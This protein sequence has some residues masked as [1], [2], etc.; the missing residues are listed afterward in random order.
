M[1]LALV[2]QATILLG[3]WLLVENT[4]PSLQDIGARRQEVAQLEQQVIA[5]ER[6]GGRLE[7]GTCLD[8]RKHSHICFRTNEASGVFQRQGDNKT[9]RIPW[10]N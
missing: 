3:V 2:V 9:Y 7:L 8:N 6:R 10:G 1:A 4:I 5:L